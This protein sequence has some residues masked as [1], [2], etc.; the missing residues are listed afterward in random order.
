[1]TGTPMNTRNSRYINT[2]AAPPY[3]PVMY[4]NLQTFPSPIA[5]PADSRMK[6]SREDSLS[7]AMFSTSFFNIPCR[8][9]WIAGIEKSQ[10]PQP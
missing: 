3:L 9:L 2:N 10:L 4:G 1:M 5:Q 6:P 8:I 7:L